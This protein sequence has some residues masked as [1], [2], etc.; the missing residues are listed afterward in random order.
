MVASTISQTGSDLSGGGT[1]ADAG[2]GSAGERGVHPLHGGGVVLVK[3]EFAQRPEHR[4][5]SAVVHVEIDGVAVWPARSPL[6]HDQV[7]HAGKHCEPV[8][9]P[10]G[11]ARRADN[12]DV[13]HHEPPG[14]GSR[15]T[16]VSRR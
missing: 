2:R 16:T 12:A 10:C 5:G 8:E 14:A 1:D 4:V 7:L 3:A 13:Q 15:R 11:D 6:E 9:E